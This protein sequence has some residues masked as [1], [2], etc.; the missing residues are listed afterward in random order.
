MVKLNFFTF[1]IDK[2]IEIIFL[3]QTVF[4]ILTCISRDRKYLQRLGRLVDH[5]VVCRRR[6]RRSARE[7]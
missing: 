4:Y 3:K 5:V 7:P 1:A 6:M 2:I